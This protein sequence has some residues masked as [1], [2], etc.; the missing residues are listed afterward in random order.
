MNVVKGRAAVT[1]NG[2]WGLNRTSPANHGR[3]SGAEEKKMALKRRKCSVSM[4][5]QLF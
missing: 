1:G 5:S 2:W 3:P 4:C